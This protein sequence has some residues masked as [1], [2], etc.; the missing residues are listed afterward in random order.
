MGAVYQR[1][2]RPDQRE[3]VAD[4][5]AAA[6]RLGGLVQRQVNGR[7]AAVHPADRV[8][9]RLHEAVDQ[10]GR[11]LGA[12]RR[13]DPSARNEAG[14]HRFEEALLPVLAQLRRFD[15]GQAPGDPA[16]Y[17]VGRF[18]VALGVFFEQH[19]QADRLFVQQCCGLVEFHP[20]HSR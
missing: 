11:D 4:A 19:V 17:L 12:G 6:H 2:A 3:V 1:A 15:R 16:A 9:D 14:H 8:A 7:H 18:L 20:T 13:V 5:A 10:R